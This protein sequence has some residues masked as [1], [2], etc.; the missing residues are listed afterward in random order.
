M[1]HSIKRRTF[2][3]TAKELAAF[4]AAQ[5]IRIEAWKN[6]RTDSEITTLTH[7]YDVAMEKMR[8]AYYRDTSDI[9]ALDQCQHVD[10]QFMRR[11][12]QGD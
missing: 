4:D 3:H 10:I 9:N 8:E 2:L 7:A 11:M 12:V 6:V 1:E 5:S